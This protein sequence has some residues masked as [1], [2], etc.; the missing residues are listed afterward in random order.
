MNDILIVELAKRIYDRFKSHSTAIYISVDLARQVI[1]YYIEFLKT[2]G[3]AGYARVNEA[4]KINPLSD[5]YI[6][7]V[8][9][10]I[11]G[12]DVDLKKRDTVW[13]II[14]GI[15]QVTLDDNKY[16][17]IWNGTYTPSSNVTPSPSPAPS[18]IF[19]PDSVLPDAIIPDAP[20]NNYMLYI[21]GGLAV[22]G[23]FTF[24]K[25]R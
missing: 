5:K 19:I 7:Y 10:K 14:S 24:M 22:A 25:K 15:M 6:N 17:P 23:L 2:S 16:R 12:S 1:Y 9:R 3:S 8:Y 4:E 13:V 20:A 18:P 11:Y 21:V